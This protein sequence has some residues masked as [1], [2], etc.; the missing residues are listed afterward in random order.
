MAMLL[1]CVLLW[2]AAGTQGV[3]GGTVGGLPQVPPRDP[4]AKPATGTGSIS[5]K[6]TAADTGVPM[7]RAAVS[8]NG[9]AGQRMTY[10][11]A[12]GRYQFTNLPPGTYTLVMSAG[13]FRAAYQSL[14]YGV[15][16]P[17]GPTSLRGRPIE[18]AEGQRVEHIDVALP[19]SG[20]ITGRVTDGDGLPAS[21]VQVGALMLRLGSEPMQTVGAQTDDL[22]QFRLYGLAAG[23]YIVMANP[24]M[25]VQAMPTESD[26]EPTGFGPTYAPGTPSRAD[27]ARIRVAPGTE[28]SIDIRLTETR[29]YSITGTV[30][31]SQGETGRSMSV[32]LMRSESNAPS[33]VGMSVAT[34]GTFTLRNVPP[35]EYEVIAR[36]SPPRQPGEAPGPDPNQE[37]AVVKVDVATSNIDGLALVTK[38][39]ATVTGEIVLE[40]PLPEGIR[41][42]VFAQPTDRRPFVSAP[43]I[44]LK[45]NTFTMRNVFGPLVVRGSVGGGPGW[46]LK[47]VLLN[48]K[49]ITDVPSTFTASDSGHLQVVF[50][51]KAPALEG[52]VID[53][54]GK[55]MSDASV[56]VFGQDP[57]TWQARSSF[58]RTMRAITD[59]KY[60]INGLREGRYFAVAVPLEVA[61]NVAQP[62]VEFLESLSKVATPVILNAGERRTV[63]LTIVRIQ[64]P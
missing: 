10:T 36:Y 51:A 7:R 26:V 55:P 45:G 63:D 8:L 24:S 61:V 59:G 32:M 2:S 27:A 49:D 17:G 62:S 29:V 41:T 11:D 40:D 22:G 47:A 34:S 4:R 6:V 1:I 28:A 16:R 15:S 46:G 54:S 53:E 56:I 21:R 48:G 23:D 5:G 44:D 58:L 13:M 9:P 30:M 64:Q 12:D 19:R 57:S 35:G 18:L 14:G 42:N 20:V 37:F 25:G 3:I 39:G 38:P 50:T 31:N 43:M 33:S 60:A 52:V